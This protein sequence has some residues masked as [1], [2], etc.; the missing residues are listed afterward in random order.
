M[1][2]SGVQAEVHDPRKPFLH[3]GARFGG[4]RR[5]QRARRPIRNDD[6]V[7]IFLYPFRAFHSDQPGADDQHLAALFEV[8]SEPEHIVHRIKG[9]LFTYAFQSFDGRHEGF[10]SRCDQEFVVGITLSVRGD[11]LMG[12]VDRRRYRVNGFDALFVVIVFSAEEQAFILRLFLQNVRDQRTGI[13]GALFSA[14]YGNIRIFVHGQD[15]FYRPF[16]SDASAD[17]QILFHI[18]SPQNKSRRWGIF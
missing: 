4:G 16:R 15:A 8:G 13:Q 14:K 6:I 10:G 9:V 5:G 7:G 3:D 18:T 12:G 1:I 2:E 11:R 17:Q